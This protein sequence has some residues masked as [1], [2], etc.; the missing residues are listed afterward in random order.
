MG[1]TRDDVVISTNIPA[2]LDGL[3]RGDAK[4]PADPGAAVYWTNGFSS[5]PRVM[6]IDQYTAVEDNL[7]EIAG[8]ARS[9]AGDRAA[10]RRGHP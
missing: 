4:W 7:A 9:N 2:R 6:A 1:V 10:R 5:G 8:H 3:P